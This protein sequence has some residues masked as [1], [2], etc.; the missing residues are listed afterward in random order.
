MKIVFL[1]ANYNRMTGIVSSLAISL[2]ISRCKCVYLT[3]CDNVNM[4]AKYI[5]KLSFPFIS[6]LRTDYITVSN[7]Q[8]GREIYGRL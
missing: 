6:Q 7:N 8:R 5:T 2:F 1:V 4:F 3:S